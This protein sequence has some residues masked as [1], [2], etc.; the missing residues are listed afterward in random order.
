MCICP[1]L[2]FNTVITWQYESTSTGYDKQYDYMVTHFI[3]HRVLQG[4][5]N[6]S[7]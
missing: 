1:T 7:S 3:Q 4:I 2:Y 5:K 6:N